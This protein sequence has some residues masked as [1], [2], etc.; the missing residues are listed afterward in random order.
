VTECAAKHSGANAAMYGRL[1]YILL[2]VMAGSEFGVYAMHLNADDA[3]PHELIP[4][5]SVSRVTQCLR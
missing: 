4:R 3:V 2:T 5:F 1:G